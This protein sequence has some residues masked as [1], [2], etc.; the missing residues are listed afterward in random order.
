[1]RLE[2]FAPFAGRPDVVHA[3][4]LRTTANT[5]ADDYPAR[6]AG[7]FGYQRHADAEQVHGNGVA[8]VT[9]PVSRAPGMDALVTRVTGLP[10]LI[11]CADCAPLFVLDPVIPAIGLAHSGR[12]GTA[13]NIA[14]AMVATL[15]HA[16]GSRPADCLALI[17]P[18]IG[19]CHYDVDLWTPLIAQ[20]H[21]AGIQQVHH[22]RICTA[23]QLDRYYSYRA[24]HGP[25]GRLF[26]LL[27]LNTGQPDSR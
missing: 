14:G 27:A 22:P 19:P 20:L 21:A 8:V 5:R 18:C 12:R 4:T 15:Q 6:V 13:A 11:R 26:A 23:C 7:H 25:T 1:M 3:F 24:E 17:G 9:A 10:L 2:T 16:Y